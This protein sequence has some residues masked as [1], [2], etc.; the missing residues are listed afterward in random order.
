LTGV[1]P[2]FQKETL[3]YTI[4]RLLSYKLRFSLITNAFWCNT[5]EVTTKTLKIFLNKGLISITVSY[6]SFHQNFIPIINVKHLLDSCNNLSIPITLYTVNSKTTVNQNEIICESLKENFD[7]EINSRWFVPVGAAKLLI[8]DSMYI[9]IKDTSEYCPVSNIMTIDPKG[10]CFPC[11]SV[12]AHSNLSF[13]N[14]LKNDF[15]TLIERR[16]NSLVMLILENEGPKG[17]YYRLPLPVRDKI[18]NDNITGTCH[19]CYNIF[20][21]YKIDEISYYCKRGTLDIIQNIFELN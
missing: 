12:G 1:E 13:G 7:F 3:D 9:K 21:V 20:S 2:F 10:F 4:D 15:E 6:D 16:N 8:D 5:L 17:I 11:C 14:I 19:L 18:S